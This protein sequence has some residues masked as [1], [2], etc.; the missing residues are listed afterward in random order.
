[1]KLMDPRLMDMA[2]HMAHVAPWPETA[3]EVICIQAVPHLENLYFGTRECNHFFDEDILSVNLDM[4]P[5]ILL[6]CLETYTIKL[7][8]WYNLV[9]ELFNDRCHSIV[10]S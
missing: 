8:G 1:M 10:E 7:S 6:F 3:K 5:Q 4:E 2:L 9:K